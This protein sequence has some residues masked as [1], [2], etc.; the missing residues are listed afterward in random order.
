MTPPRATSRSFPSRAPTPVPPRTSCTRSSFR[1]RARA[2]PGP[3]RT[4]SSC[5]TT[6]SSTASPATAARPLDLRAI[7]ASARR[8]TRLTSYCHMTQLVV[9]SYNIHRGIGLDQR[10]DLVRTAAV[11]AEIGPDV[12]G[13]QEVIREDGAAHRDHAAFLAERLGMTL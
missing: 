10:L 4:R 8:A 13:L 11:I 3:S 9:G 5:T 12:V 6:S 7:E 2:C 1:L